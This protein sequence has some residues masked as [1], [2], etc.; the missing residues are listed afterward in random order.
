MITPAPYEWFVNWENTRWKRRGEDYNEF[1]QKLADRLRHELEEVV[2]AVRGRIEIAELSTP[3]TTRHFVNYPHGEIYGMSA[4]P[5][6]FR[7]RCLTPRT[8][9]RNLYLTGQDVCMLSVVASTVGGILT[10]SAVL[11]RNLMP[12]VTKPQAPSVQRAA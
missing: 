9:I 6:R 11:G 10:A 1:K 7:L 2:P 8:A 3:L 12:V 4:G 5:E